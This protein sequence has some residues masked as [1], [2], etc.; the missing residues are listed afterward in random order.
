MVHKI[1]VDNTKLML[2]FQRN[3]CIIDELANAY[4][5]SYAYVNP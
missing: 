2:I 5:L 3:Q 1:T 4:G